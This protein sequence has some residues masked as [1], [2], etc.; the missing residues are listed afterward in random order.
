MI[1][2]CEVCQCNCSL[3]PFKNSDR[4]HL[5]AAFHEYLAGKDDMPSVSEHRD[6]GMQEY[7]DMVNLAVES[8]E[9][10]CIQTIMTD[11]DSTTDG[12]RRKRRV[13]EKVASQEPNV[14]RSVLNSFVDPDGSPDPGQSQEAVREMMR[15]DKTPGKKD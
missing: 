2:S 14:P 12:M 4:E 10:R 15:W 7:R 8:F 1:S 13:M 5:K 9:A 3:G 11:K 6:A